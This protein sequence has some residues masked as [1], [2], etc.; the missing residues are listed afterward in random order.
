MT[1][2]P[3]GYVQ[4]EAPAPEDGAPA[5]RV[6]IRRDSME[7]M[8]DAS[9]LPA[10]VTLD[11]LR[12]GLNAAGVVYGIDMAVLEVLTRVRLSDYMSCA[13]GRPPRN[14][15]DAQLKYYVDTDRQGLPALQ[16]DGRVD[17]KNLNNF[18]NV[19]IGEILVEKAPPTPGVSGTDVLGRPVPPKAGRDMPLPLGKNVSV[20]DNSLLVAAIDGQLFIAD[21]KVN[22]LQVVVIDG[23]V[24]YSTG[25]ID[26]LGSVVVTG[27]VQPGFS[28]KAGGNVEIRGNIS[29]GTVEA[30][31]ITVHTGIQGM[32]RS[33]IKAN[34]RLVAKFIE[35]ATVY[36]GHEIVVSD[37]MLHSRAF[38]GRRIIVDGRNGL[39]IGG[40]LVAGEEI[41]VRTAGNQAQVP[42]ELDVSIDPRLKDELVK[43]RAELKETSA[44][45]DEL[46]RSLAYL[47]AQG[48]DGLP[49]VKRERYRAMAEE[50]APLPDRV[51][52]LRLRAADLESLLYSLKP[53]RINVAGT[54]HKG[55]RVTIGP[56]LR[57]I[58]APLQHLTLFAHED[59]IKF[60]T[61]LGNRRQAT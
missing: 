19:D 32:G 37:V 60:T 34:T 57:I 20:V 35:S 53:G 23:D 33:V 40:R 9:S 13:R 6:L 11:E 30:V 8:I 10:A 14:G 56:L 15:E 54:L 31:N 24:D 46:N 43:V 44:R 42:T 26:F 22:V 7:A 5:I 41:R 61:Y 39:V 27:S 1:K 12:A 29:G 25:N 18:V 4:P 59:T 55:V 58:D 17:F 51:E 49:A 47:E 45:A 52:E 48:G 21:N 16:E 50:Y 36:A 2:T 38:A 3:A 28:V